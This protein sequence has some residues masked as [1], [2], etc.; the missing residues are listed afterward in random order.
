MSLAL[1]TLLALTAIIIISCIFPKINPGLLAVIAALAIGTR[2]ADMAIKPILA[3]FPVDLFFLLVS[4]CG[5]FGIAQAN[6]TLP[7]LVQKIVPIIHGRAVL[8]PLLLFFISF[9]LSAI[10]PGNIAAVALLATIAMTMA[11]RYHISPLLIAIMIVTGANAGAFSPFAPTGIIAIGLM[12]DIG[13]DSQSL[14]WIVFGAAALLQSL[15]ALG[16]YSLFLA[17]WHHREG[18][19]AAVIEPEPIPTAAP[20]WAPIDIMALS[21]SMGWLPVVSGN[22]TLERATAQAKPESQLT[23]RQW[24]TLTLIAAMLLGVTVFDIPLVLMASITLAIL[25]FANLGD[26]EAVMRDLPWGTMLMVTG[27]AVLIGLMEKTG[28]LDLATTL[29]ASAT[30]PQFINGALALITGVVSAF[31]S[32]SGVVMPAFIPLIPGLA[33][34]MGILDSVVQMVISVC[35]GSHMVDVSPLS[36]LGALALA[37]IP[38]KAQRDRA[39]RGLLVW[40]MS[41]A[42]VGAA[43]AFIFL[44][45][46]W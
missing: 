37:A 8:V 30:R 7:V 39:F 45:W 12:E 34:K 17:R 16:A 2:L 25:I 35:V 31:S 46:L 6:G 41:M 28:G 13:L 14:S 5:V 4:I 40:G 29:I 21:Y 11:A 42:F 36:T 19:F 20:R 15:T 27:I 10:G 3:G 23:K 18:S 32:S 9:L 1:T 26:F 43:L 24:I 38:L 33:E 22:R 44:D